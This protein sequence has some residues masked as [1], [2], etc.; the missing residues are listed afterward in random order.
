MTEREILLNSLV[1]ESLS[2]NLAS[3]QNNVFVEISDAQNIINQSFI[4]EG[5]KKVKID[6]SFL[7]SGTYK[8]KIESKKKS[9]ALAFHKT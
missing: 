4:F 7:K 1:H 5:G 8:L 3:F 2:L 9:I 6:V